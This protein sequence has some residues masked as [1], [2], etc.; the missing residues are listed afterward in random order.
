MTMP[1]P[2]FVSRLRLLSFLAVAVS[3]GACDTVRSGPTP[4]GWTAQTDTVGDT[5]TVRTLSGSVWGEERTLVEEMSIGALEGPEEYLLGRI[6]AIAVDRAGHVYLLDQQGAALRVYDPDGTFVRAIGRE[7]QGPGELSRPGAGLQIL[8]DGKVAVRDP[9]NGRIQFFSADGTPE[10]FGRLRAQFDTSEP[11]VADTADHLFTPNIR[12]GGVPLDQWDRGMVEYAPNGD[13]I[14]FRSHPLPPFE[15]A[16]VEARNENSWNRTRVPFAPAQ[17][18]AFSRFGAYAHG[19]GATYS[20]DILH[21]DGSVLRVE[22]AYEPVPVQSGERASA[23]TTTTRSMRRVEPGWSWNGPAIPD[24][25]PAYRHLFFSDEGRVWALLNSVGYD[26]G[27][28]TYTASPGE[29][30][31]PNQWREPNVFDVFDR[32]GRFLGR[33]TAPD[34]LRTNPVPVIRGD[35]VWAIVA[36][37]L[38]VQYLKRF[39]VSP[40]A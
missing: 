14:G 5:I 1:M 28:P 15:E 26:T 33:V 2:T 24:D 30:D 23:E 25:K 6:A 16:F 39:R 3:Q 32:E 12:D 11:M 7:G 9:G 20:I 13:S 40:S 22:R 31:A 18:Y 35:Q 36:D 4:A 17:R 8:S 21:R 19:T 38:D 10:G 27:E 34:G 37:E 29:P